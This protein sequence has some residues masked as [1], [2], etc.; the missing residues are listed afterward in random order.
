M[1]EQSLTV[2]QAL[3]IVKE[4]MKQTP[5]YKVF[6]KLKQYR[7][8]HLRTETVDTTRACLALDYHGFPVTTNLVGALLEKDSNSGISQALH[9]LGDKHVLLLKRDN[10]KIKQREPS[11]EWMVH[12][13][14]LKR[15]REGQDAS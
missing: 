6:F 14:F 3:E 9:T 15:F 12:P 8:K 10:R 5:F 13:A 1:S 11:L 2:E 4:T 7:V